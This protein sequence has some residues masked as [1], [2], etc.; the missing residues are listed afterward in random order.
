MSVYSKVFYFPRLT[1]YSQWKSTDVSEEYITSYIQDR[2]VSKARK[3][4]ESGSGFIP[5][6]RTLH[7]HCSENLKSNI[8]LFYFVFWRTLLV[9]HQLSKGLLLKNCLGCKRTDLCYCSHGFYGWNVTGLSLFFLCL[10]VETSVQD[11]EKVTNSILLI[12]FLSLISLSVRETINNIRGSSREDR[13]K[14]CTKRQTK[15]IVA[16]SRPKLFWICVRNAAAL[17]FRYLFSPRS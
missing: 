9:R 17:L 13:T 3:H 8:F 2:R 10:L 1:P 6:G 15:W 11:I 16:S 14:R 4:H 12:T 7:S 5:G